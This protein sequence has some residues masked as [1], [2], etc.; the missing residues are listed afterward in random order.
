[1]DDLE[2]GLCWGT[3]QQANLVEMIEAAGRH[4][5][6]TLSVQPEALAAT[7]D[8]LG[9]A[10]LR[11]R[12]QDAG[13]R[14]RILD[15][16]WGALPGQ[17]RPD[18]SSGSNENLCYR[19]AEAVEAPILNVTHYRGR[20]TPREQLIEAIG[21]VC[22]RAGG[23]GFQVVLEFI[24]DTGLP[25]L[26]EASEI[27]RAVGEANC[28]I[29]LDPWHLAR[30]G[31]TLD[32]VLRLPPGAIGAFQLCDRTPPAPDAVYVPM[33]GRDLPGEGELPLCALTRAVAA[34]NPKVTAELEVFSAELR[35][36]S[37]DAAAA[38]AATAVKTW[39]A[40]C[41]GGP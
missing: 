32:D 26:N 9:A 8:E 11:K 38:R 4:G 34:N 21:G 17:G 39:R 40:R 30:S 13:V 41:A 20:P 27:V 14:V 7:I 33:T 37:I 1:M 5:F 24:P 19:A 3:L 16:I 31:G 36:L 25:S 2:I 12:L 28:A 6:T 15:A 29:N 18:A 23:R 10:A 35:E 22:R